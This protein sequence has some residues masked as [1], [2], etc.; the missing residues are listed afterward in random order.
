MTKFVA[1]IGMALLMIF[2]TL[3]N[4]YFTYGIWPK[5]WFSFGFFFITGLILLF[6]FDEIH[7]EMK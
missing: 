3:G 5:S 1:I 7:K 6:V 4:F 2:N